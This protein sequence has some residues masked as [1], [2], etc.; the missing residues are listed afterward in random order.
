MVVLV[1]GGR[2][3]AEISSGFVIMIAGCSESD[4]CTDT[5]SSQ[6]GRGDSVFVHEAS[7]VV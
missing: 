6:S 2:V 7:D 3:E 1:H 5:M 4:L